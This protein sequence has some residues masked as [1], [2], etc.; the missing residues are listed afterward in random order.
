MARSTEESESRTRRERIDPGL[1]AAGWTVAPWSPGT[2]LSRCRHH[3]LTEY[4]TANGPADYALVVDGQLLGIVEAK[5]LTLG[6]QNVLIQAERYSKGV[7]DGPIDIRGY[8]VPFLYS[9]NG[10][11][12]WFH[13]VRHK[14]NHSRRV[15]RFH[16]PAA[17]R[18]AFSRDFEAGCGW[19]SSHPNAHSRLRPY[20]VEANTA[21]E[22]AIGDRKRQMLVAMATGTGKT[23]T[24]VNEAYR[25]LESGVGKRILFLVDRRALAAQAVKAFASFEPEPNKKFDKLYEVYS[26]RF[27]RADLDED[28][29]FDPKVLPGS[30]L[31]A[32]EPKHAFVYVCTIQRMA[33]NLFGRSA[34]WSTEG[35]EIDDDADHVDIPTHAFDVVIADECHRGYTTAELSLWRDTLDNFDAVKIGLT[36]TPAAHT[37]AYFNDVVYRYDYNRA[38]REGHLVDYDAVAIHSDVRLKGV[39]LKTGEQ[40]LSVDAESGAERLDALED[41]RD[42]GASDVEQAAQLRPARP[43]DP[44]ARGPRRRRP[45]RQLP[46]RRPGRRGLQDPLRGLRPP[47]RPPPPARH[48]HALQPGGEGERRLLHE[49][50]S[51]RDRLDLRRE[52]ERPRHHEEGPAPHTRPLRRV[53]E[54]LRHRP[55]RPEQE[56]ARPVEGGPLAH[57]RHRRGR[58]ARLQARQLQVAQGGIA[59]R[60]G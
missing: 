17:L 11:T 9:T 1:R 21:I 37:K 36:A 29:P 40:V 43:D 4:P 57:F 46:L 47:H 51:L 6:P 50:A 3:A 49:G 56:E 33:I 2:D 14:L 26:Q 20:Q 31:T 10:E 18:E 38:V 27:Q 23:F 32:P 13:D 42:F 41:E 59:R 16:T 25:L 22:T 7:L 58:E 39:F 55:E 60:R 5:K 15:A 44:E 48:V 12:I 35:D 30:Y 54:V 52:D 45:P 53:C 28:A 19:F 24:M 8:R 34:V